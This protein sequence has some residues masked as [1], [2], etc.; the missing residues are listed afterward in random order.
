MLSLVYFASNLKT[1]LKSFFSQR[2]VY[3]TVIIGVSVLVLGTLFP[4]EL[5]YLRNMSDHAVRLILFLVFLGLFFLMINQKRL[6]FVSFAGAAILALFLK[7]FS[8]VNLN[9]PTENSRQGLLISNYNLINI[10]SEYTDFIAQIRQSDAD[11]LSFQ[12]VD[13]GW[14]RMLKKALGNDYPYVAELIRIDGFGKMIFLKRPYQRMDTFYFNQIPDLHIRF[15]LDNTTCHLVSTQ[16]V[17]PFKAYMGLQS[18]DHVETV[19]SYIQSLDGPVILSGEF[20]QVYWSKELRNL[21][22]STRLSNSRRFVTSVNSKVPHEHIFFSEGLECMDVME[23]LD[24]SN[25]HVGVEA[26]FRLSDEISA[27]SKKIFQFLN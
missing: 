25:A 17:P 22:E 15:Q 8:N 27:R 2:L 4:I 26:E 9:Y 5:P 12:E 10:Q 3:I 19:G 6:L 13:P 1:R 11:I 23:L 18:K 14:G 24:P 20:N 21:V 7:N 16:I